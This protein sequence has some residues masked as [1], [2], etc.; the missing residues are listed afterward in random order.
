MQNFTTDFTVE[1]SPEQV[2]TAITDVRAWW[3]GNIE[4][5]TDQL[6]AEFTYRYEQ[7]HY[8]KQRIS[9]LTPGRRVVWQVLD[10]YLDFTDD[11]QEWVGSEIIFEVTPEA[12]RTA[13]RFS[14]VG[15]TPEVEC[16]DKCSA[17]WGFY[18][19]GSLRRLLTTGEGAPN[20]TDDHASSAAS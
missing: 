14:H 8:S 2:F 4:G 5:A 17:A 9:E 7:V 20:P 12:D 6:G 13:V 1:Q 16:Y 3:S 19:N 15:L 11:P 10:A 18:I